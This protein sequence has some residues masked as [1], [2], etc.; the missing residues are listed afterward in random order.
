[1]HKDWCGQE[2]GSCQTSCALDESMPCSPC[3]ELLGDEGQTIDYRKCL[4][5]GCDVIML[6]ELEVDAAEAER[7]QRL[8]ED[9]YS[10]DFKKEGIEPCT[11]LVTW[12]VA[13]DGR[14]SASVSIRTGR[15]FIFIERILQDSINGNIMDEFVPEGHDDNV[16]G[17]HVFAPY[18][19]RVSYV[20]RFTGKN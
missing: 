14:H 12:T 1:M 16:L 3:C 15:D 8:L 17:D 19:D 20:L 18:D 7:W 11:I 10:I 2:C 5:A 4:D 9:P 6:E 13:F